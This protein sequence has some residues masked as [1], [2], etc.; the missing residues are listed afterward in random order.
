MIITPASK[1]TS[2]G[3]PPSL[4]PTSYAPERANKR[5]SHRLHRERD[6]TIKFEIVKFANAASNDQVATEIEHS[7]DVYR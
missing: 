2:E 6:G 5:C 7:I 1:F 4:K 3:R